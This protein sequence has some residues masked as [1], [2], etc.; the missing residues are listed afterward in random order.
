MD[1][2]LTY[3]AYLNIV[4]DHEHN[5]NT[6]MTTAFANV[7]GLLQQDNAHCHNDRI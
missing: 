7:S 5:D 3:N 4:A 1:V 2:T 6:L